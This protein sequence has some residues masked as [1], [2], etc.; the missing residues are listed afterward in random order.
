MSRSKLEKFDAITRM[1]NVYDKDPRHRG[2]WSKGHFGNEH[3]LVL[4]LACGKGDYARGLAEI[5]PEKNFIGIDLKGNRIYTG[6]NLAREAELKNVAFIRAQIDHLE[7][8][9][10]PEEVDEIW[11]TF[12]DPFLK[13]SRH[14]K[15]LTSKKFIEIYRKVLKKNG[16]VNL[17]TDSP[18]LYEYTKEVIE[19]MKLPLIRDCADVYGEE[20]QETELF[21]IQTYYEKMHLLD[22][23]TIHYLKFQVE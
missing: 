5:F 11:I 21:G 22:K 6:A 9:F 16:F 14:K 8:Y 1:S 3:P 7:E 2:R 13:N 4:E 20:I 10:A 18:Q 19:E 12:P 17:K 15:R 23:R